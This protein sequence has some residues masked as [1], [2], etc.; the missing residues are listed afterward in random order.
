MI[1][2]GADCLLCFLLFIFLSL[3]L[4]QRYTVLLIPKPGGKGYGHKACLISIIPSI[5]RFS[6][7]SNG[8]VYVSSWMLGY[9]PFLGSRSLIHYVMY[10]TGVMGS[11]VLLSWLVRL[12]FL[13]RDI[14]EEFLAAFG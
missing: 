7:G 8:S 4:I 6:L 14:I 11:T 12:A 2:T 1:P 5:G 13:G 3:S 10:N 9:S